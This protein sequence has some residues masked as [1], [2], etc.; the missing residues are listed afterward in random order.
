M[1]QDSQG[2][3]AT[4]TQMK[5]VRFDK[6]GGIEVLRVADVPV[7]EPA[8]GEVL[9]KV[10]AASQSRALPVALDRSSCSWPGE[11]GRK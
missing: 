7:P 5:A 3:T 2:K 10:K 4:V 8:Q 1:T 9:V 11:L 6:Y